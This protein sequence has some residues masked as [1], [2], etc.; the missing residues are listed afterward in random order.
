[1]TTLNDLERRTFRAARDDGLFDVM[2]AAFL[3]MFALAPLLSD[4]LGDFWSSAIF[5]PIWYVTYLVMRFTR[6]RVVAPRLGTIEPG[7][8]RK[9]RLRRVNLILLGV[10]SLA[11]AVGIAA[12]AGWLSNRVDLAGLTYP[13]TLGFAGLVIFSLVAYS[14]STGRYAVYGLLVALAPLAGELLWQNDKA[15]HHGFPIAFGSVSTIM[16]SVGILR[17][18]TLIRRHPLP[19]QTAA[20]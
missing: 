5:G 4:S 12:S 1:M 19:D 10:N 6:E 11:L 13:I 9:A 7:G 20:V 16:F 15:T 8:D 14:T 18:V 3:S 2:M 17:F